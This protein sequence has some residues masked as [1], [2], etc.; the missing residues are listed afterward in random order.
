MLENHP[1]RDEIRLE[2][3]LAALGNPLR[4]SVVAILAEGGEYT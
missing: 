4:M 2:N 1:Q 3:V